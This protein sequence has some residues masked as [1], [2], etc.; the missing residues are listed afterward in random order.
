MGQSAQ[1]CLVNPH[2]Q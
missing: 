1:K 2:L